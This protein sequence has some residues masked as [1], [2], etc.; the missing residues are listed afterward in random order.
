MKIHSIAGKSLKRKTKN[1]KLTNA[2]FSKKK[3][4]KTPGLLCI[5]NKQ[6]WVV[7]KTAQKSFK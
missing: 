3:G 7:P 6:H 2:V 4:K 1:Q 5:S